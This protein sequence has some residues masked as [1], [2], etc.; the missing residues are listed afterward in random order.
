MAEDLHG[1][2]A[3]KPR[4]KKLFK[5]STSHRDFSCLCHTI[6]LSLRPAIT[7]GLFIL[8]PYIKVNRAAQSVTANTADT[9][10]LIDLLGKT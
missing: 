8:A 3:F 9:Q 7:P 2:P 5:R 4:K 6:T 1:A 10:D